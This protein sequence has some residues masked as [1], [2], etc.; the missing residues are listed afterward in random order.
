MLAVLLLPPAAAFGLEDVRRM[1]E[2][3]EAQRT[4]KASAVRGLV[5]RSAH[6]QGFYRSPLNRVIALTVHAGL[7]ALLYFGWKLGA[8]ALLT[9]VAGTIE[10]EL[11]IFTRPTAALDLAS[12][13]AGSGL[14]VVPLPNGIALAG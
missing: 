14:H 8:R 5:H 9:L 7:A 3:T 12:G 2:E 1:A 4:A 6:Q 10:W 11:Q 13:H